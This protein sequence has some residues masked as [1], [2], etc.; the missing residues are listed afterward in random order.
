VESEK[1][2]KM[3]L[4]LDIPEFKGKTLEEIRSCILSCQKCPC[5]SSRSNIVFG[6]GNPNARLVF[7]GEAP[8]VDED[9]LGVPFVGRAGVMLGKMI[10]AI[11]FVRDDVYICNLLKC[12]PPQNRAPTDEEVSA[13][14]PYLYAQII[15][16]RPD[17][18]ISLGT[19]ATNAML[20]IKLPTPISMKIFRKADD[21]TNS[22]PAAKGLHP[23]S[24]LRG[25]FHDFFGVPLMP[26][27]HPAY[28]LRASQHKAE[29]WGDLKMVEGMLQG[30]DLKS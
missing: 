15:A 14:I 7:V 26:T 22:L 6:A 30:L 25:R 18:I 23:M 3:K 29:T 16:I 11:G 10:A 19:Y 8:G 13:C 2:T 28:L 17:A 20:G 1:Q 4:R 9:L 5:A 21:T 27:W 12:R 24:K